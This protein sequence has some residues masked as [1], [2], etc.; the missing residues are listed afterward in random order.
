MAPIVMA[1][2]IVDM[3][4]TIVD[5]APTIVDMA[6]ELEASPSPI[7]THTIVPSPRLPTIEAVELADVMADVTIDAAID[8]LGSPL[9][10]SLD[11]GPQQVARHG[12]FHM[13]LM[14]G[15]MNLA[16]R[17]SSYSEA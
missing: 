10:S 11:M 9:G 12:A 15:L 17:R 1:A 13:Q 7:V 14:A 5:M 8:A 3:A 16:W 6:V 4:P 2:T